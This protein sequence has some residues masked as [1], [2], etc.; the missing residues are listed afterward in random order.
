MKNLRMIVRKNSLV[1]QLKNGV[2]V[3]KPAAEPAKRFEVVLVS[4]K[5]NLSAKR[6]P[7]WGRKKPERF[8]WLRFEYTLPF[9]FAALAALNICAFIS[10]LRSP[11]FQEPPP[12]PPL[13][14]EPEDPLPELFDGLSPAFLKEPKPAQNLISQ[15]YRDLLSRD[16]V[17]DFFSRITGS[18]E[19]A[20]MILDAAEA[21]KV[22]P[23]L[24]FAVAWEE[25][26]YRPRAVNA[27][28]RNGSVDRGLFQLNSRSFPKL[29][30][31]DFFDP[32]INTWY[33]LAHLRWCL[34]TGGSEVVAL[35]MY[36]AGTVRVNANGTPRATLEYAGRVLNSCRK[37]DGFFEAEIDRLNI[38][39]PGPPIAP[40]GELAS[41]ES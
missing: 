6:P 4:G 16:L 7:D 32:R 11:P 40:L 31:T 35:A 23:S 15:Y 13:I 12:A 9:F 10:L 38:E 34:D 33:G 30:E 41:A 37:I 22:P 21:H 17:I 1:N 5:P 27:N 25:S 19:I 24:A 3:S 2:F 29:S 18:R 20:E 39:I 26:R 14:Q 36:N 8:L 28:N